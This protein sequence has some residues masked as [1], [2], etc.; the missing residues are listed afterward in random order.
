[1]HKTINVIKTK[2]IIIQINENPYL[3]IHNKTN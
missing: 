3:R 2:V 1:M